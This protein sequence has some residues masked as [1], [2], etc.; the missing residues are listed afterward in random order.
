MGPTAYGGKGS[1]GRV[2]NGDG[3]VD[4]TSCRREQYTMAS[5]PTLPLDPPPPPPLPLLEA[6]MLKIF[7]RAFGTRGFKLTLFE[8]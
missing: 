1:K 8:S 3:P 5:C 7:L 4:A 6:D 2:A